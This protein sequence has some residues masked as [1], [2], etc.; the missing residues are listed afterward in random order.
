MRA[1]IEEA[2]KSGLPALEALRNDM[3]MGTEWESPAPSSTGPS[4]VAN[5]QR[6]PDT[7]R[8]DELYEDK[9]E[10][11]DEDEETGQDDVVIMEGRESKKRRVA[12]KAQKQLEQRSKML[13][14]QPLNRRERRAAMREL[15]K[16]TKREE[17]DDSEDGF[18][19]DDGGV[20]L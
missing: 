8:E 2:T 7:K 20:K 18:F 15:E 11:E 6:K 4:R 13:N 14:A 1:L 9:D 16:Q 10:D 19:E 17:D 5:R 3:S 12:E